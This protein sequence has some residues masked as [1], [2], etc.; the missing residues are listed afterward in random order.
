METEPTIDI[1]LAGLKE[2][3]STLE[4]P[5]VPA[6]PAA[7]VVPAPEQVFLRM[8]NPW[9]WAG[10]AAL[11]VV[12]FVLWWFLGKDEKNNR[13]NDEEEEEPERWPQQTTPRQEYARHY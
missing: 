7:S 3:L 11:V 1:A 13:D 10:V 12:I 4:V 6:V 9:M 5:A 2:R 8:D